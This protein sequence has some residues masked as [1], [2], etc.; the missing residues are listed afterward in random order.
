METAFL[1]VVNR[2][3]EFLS[4]TGGTERRALGQ[5]RGVYATLI[6]LAMVL[7][8][9]GFL[10]ALAPVGPGGPGASGPL[11]P[12]AVPPT[13]GDLVVGS[14]QTY[15]IQ[16][17]PGVHTYYQG[18]NI[19]VLSGGTLIVE[20]ITLSFVEYV[21][22]N[23]T[24]EQRLS[25]IYYFD[26][27]GTVTFSNATLTTDVE[28]LNAYAKLNLTVT[29]TLTATRT[30]FAFPGWFF[31]SGPSADAT[32]NDST[33]TSN[34]AVV[35]LVEPQIILSDTSYAPTLD[36]V[37][38]AKLNLF[39]SE[40]ENT[41][42]DNLL[43]SGYPG[44]TPL[45]AY[46]PLPSLTSAGLSIQP[47][48]PS[49]PAAL[50][51]DWSYP[52]AT[53]LVGNVTVQYADTN[54]PGTATQ[55]NDT[56]ATLGVEYG[57][58]AYPLGTVT[59]LNSTGL[60]YDTLLLTPALLSAITEGGLLQ[61]LNFTGSFD[62]TAQLFLTFTNVVGPA[63]TL[64]RL[65]FALGMSGP[66][67]NIVVSGAGSELS[68]VDS[69]VDLNWNTVGGGLF[70]TA[71]PF[72]WSSNK[73]D[74]ADGA[75][76]YLANLTTGSA[77][78]G[79]FST[80]AILADPLSQVNFYRWAQFNITS[81]NSQPLEGAQ[82]SAFYAYNTDQSNNETTSALNN[83]ATIDPAMWVYLQYWDDQRG[84]SSW[85]VSNAAGEASILLAS[86]NLTYLTL[87]DGIFLGGYHVG[88]SVPGFTVPSHWFNWSVAPY[89]TGVAAG[90]AYYDEPDFG[91]AQSF[92][93]YA[94]SIAVASAAGPGVSTLS[95]TQQYYTTGTLTYSGTATAEVYVYALSTAPGASQILVGA[96][97]AVAGK[98][99]T[100]AWTVPLPLSGG[101]SYTLS[102]TA[103]ANGAVSKPYEI[104][105]TYSVPSSTPSSPTSFFTQ[106][107]L[108]LPMWTWLAIAAAIVVAVIAVLLVS[109][110]TAAGKLVECGEC[111]NL[112]PADATVCPKCGAEFESDLIRC[113]RCASTIPADSKFCPECSAQLLGKPG[114]GGEEVE[115][116][117]YADFTE[118]YRAEA[119]R[120]LGD[121]YNEGSF[122]DWWKRQPTYTSYSQ[123]KLQQGQGVA[124]RA[125]MAAPPMGTAT[126]PVP[127]PRAA[128]LPSRP[129][130]TPPRVG[131]GA[132]GMGAAPAAAPPSSP[133]AAAMTAPPEAPTAAPGG[134]LKPCPNCGNEIPPEYL[135]CP[136]CGSVT[137]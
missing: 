50:V 68:V 30:T 34:P 130:P 133:A 65:T 64:D 108:G 121:N 119:K 4:Q 15:V 75:V 113:S 73:L 20:N 104:A 45:I 39:G 46:S 51:Q 100:V 78:P 3:T 70:T 61:Y 92:A 29:G 106:K 107:L 56:T 62:T 136:F 57:G 69:M 27:G 95:L 80:S 26:D 7:G 102:V 71:P 72:P 59:F 25:H 17:T 8:S 127:A 2:S 128:T 12:L 101:T 43:A 28:L 94:F 116:Q 103:T 105:G 60:G 19:T 21:G 52:S 125:G 11:E 42:A 81:A 38:G 40:V 83:I 118:K 36:V 96:G 109:R 47:Q 86:S 120:E 63:V 32:L 67:Y 135:V 112:I 89:P 132:A 93:G 131:G 114:E 74:F 23:G 115:R 117:G 58:T 44:P 13:H 98:P 5:V 77:I 55:S 110:R 91:P 33:I 53:A 22:D 9:M 79:V 66:A 10:L 123:W 88:V 82:V 126:A 84:V 97:S 6:V 31:V 90:T 134:A 48:G 111:G 76:G 124:S 14:G 16:S 24:A 18:G 35:G 99:F 129:A 122:W 49:D 54:G 85:G 41:Y 37:G 87:P 1:L 137:Q